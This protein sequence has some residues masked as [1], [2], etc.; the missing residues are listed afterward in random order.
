MQQRFRFDKEEWEKTG[1]GA[2]IAGGGAVITYLLE[3][4]P[5]WDFGEATP[6]VV[7]I[8]SIALNALWQYVK[9]EKSEI[10][11]QT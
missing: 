7:G 9:G 4:V 3:I 2:L 8:A 5:N 11:N 10:G 1:R 6:V